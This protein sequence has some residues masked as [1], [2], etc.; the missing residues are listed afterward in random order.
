MTR[1]VEASATLRLRARAAGRLLCAVGKSAGQRWGWLGASLALA[2]ACSKLAEDCTRTLTCPEETRVEAA[3]PAPPAGAGGDRLGTTV[4]VPREDFERRSDA[5][6]LLNSETDVATLTDAGPPEP[7][8]PVP[9]GLPPC[10]L[11]ADCDEGTVCDTF[12]AV[13]VGC[14]GNADCATASAPRCDPSTRACGG[15]AS[16]SDCRS[17]TPQCREDGACVQCLE[18]E[19]CTDPVAARC[20]DD[21]CSACIADSDCAHIAGAARCTEG[22]CV[23]CRGNAD[24]GDPRRPVCGGGRCGG[25]DDDA[26]CGRFSAAPAC[27]PG[28]ACVQCT[29]NRHC[30]N[31]RAPRCE[32]TACAPCAE[33]SDC[34]HLQGRGVCDTSQSP[35]EC[36]QCTRDA[37]DACQSASGAQLVCDSLARRCTDF[38]PGTAD[39]CAPCV[40][41]VHCQQAPLSRLCVEQRFDGVS[42]GHFCLPKPTAAENGP[43]CRARVTSVFIGDQLSIDGAQADMCHPSTTTCTGLNDFEQDEFVGADCGN[44]NGGSDALCGAPGLDDGV[45]VAVGQVNQTFHCRIPCSGNNDCPLGTA[46]TGGLCEE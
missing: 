24:C 5:G 46:C 28:G 27:G 39:L 20:Q 37:D 29:D 22:R 9:P 15:C 38:S 7:L 16:N 42:V 3:E 34:S 32:G 6:P 31:P 44:A 30:G 23:E 21:S 11:D 25:C 8:G 13:C 1:N 35:R 45:C 40:A 14:R 17:G 2:L 36:V 26:D 4:L 18:S 43:A 10:A 19:Q 41:D 33:Q 12:F